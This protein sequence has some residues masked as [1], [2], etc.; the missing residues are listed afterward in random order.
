MSDAFYESLATYSQV[1]ASLLFIV[2]MVVI[3]RRFIAPAVIASQERKNA[4][5]LESEARRDAARA[6][7]EVAQREIATAD[8]EARAIR[9]RAEIDAKAV[10]DRILRDAHSEGARL[11]RNADGEL[12][13][14]R[15]AARENLRNDLLEKAMQIARDASA[16][17]DE[18]TNR[19]LVGE[20]VDT[21]ER[22]NA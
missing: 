20:A 1:V 17:L 18:S 3:W 9:A 12:D 10:R 16:H 15:A 8:T 21:A 22:G 6:E 19:R 11:V 4:E 5:L 14:G 7:T 2:V 13:R